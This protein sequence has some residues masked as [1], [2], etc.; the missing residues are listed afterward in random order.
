MPDGQKICFVV[1]GFGEKTD[2]QSNPQRVLNLNKTYE[3]IIEPAVKDAGLKCVRADQI[4]H[5]TVIDK[6]MYENLLDADVVVAD[7]STSN[8]N[9]IYE[10]GVR[11]ALKPTTTI[12]M[13]EN[14]FNFPFDLSHL[15]IL[16]YEHLGKEIGYGEVLRVKEA[17][18]QRLV[19]L[20]DKDEVDSPVY[21]FLPSLTR[22]ERAA[23]TLAMAAPAPSSVPKDD[24]SFAELMNSSVRPRRPL[25]GRPTGSNRWRSSNGRARCSHR[26]PTSCS[27]SRLRPTSPS[28]PTGS[29]RCETPGP[30]SS[31]S[32]RQHPPTRKLSGLWGAVHKRL[33]EEGGDRADL[34]HAI[35]AYERGFFLKND[36]YNGINYAFMLD[37]R[38]SLSAGDDAVADRVLARRVR[39]RVL[40]ICEE[41]AK[42]GNLL[43][44]E[45][46]WVGATKVE[47]LFGLGRKQEAETLKQAVVAKERERLQA[48]GGSANEADWKE[49]SLSQQLAKLEKLLPKA[50][51]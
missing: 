8:A 3:Y 1:M 22:A 18:K 45:P 7:L 14:N 44:D 24:K 43:G 2:F 47:A 6:P 12:V 33:W 34:D 23:A 39:T 46:F 38:A 41:K 4:I 32:R 20:L 35:N 16:K 11:H 28:C 25:R 36:Y 21:L 19:E 9:A 5:S 26:T 17:L 49:A 31:N 13:A 10:L 29:P 30:S 37:V 50:P 42:A 15:S 48:V 51:G 27:S 40:D